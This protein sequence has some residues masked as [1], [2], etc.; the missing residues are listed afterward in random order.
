MEKTA[1]PGPAEALAGGVAILPP[2]EGTTTRLSHLAS[3]PHDTKSA[4]PS[5]DLRSDPGPDEA[6]Q[7]PPP[8]LSVSKRVLI[9]SIIT[10]S[11]CVNSGSGMGLTI[12]L[13]AIQTELDMREVDLQWVTS[14]YALTA[15]GFL[16]LSGRL[17]D[18][19]GRKLVFCTGLVWTAVWTLIG[20]FMKQGPA[21]IITRALAGCGQAMRYVFI[22][23]QLCLLAYAIRQGHGSLSSTPSAIGIIATNFSGQARSTAFAAF[24]AGAPIGAAFGMVIGGLL[25]AY[26]P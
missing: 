10:L 3:S 24:S 25:T 20:G 8:T 12:A 16:L 11:M 23:A 9:A 15:G 26:S 5:S 4:L 7:P 18:V 13:P 22:L 1:V 21:L 6:D 2:L 17:S 19:R 14:V